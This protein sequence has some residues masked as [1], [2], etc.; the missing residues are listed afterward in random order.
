MKDSDI[1]EQDSGNELGNEAIEAAYRWVVMRDR[2][3]T[4]EEATRLV[5]WLEADPANRSAWEQAS[6]HWSKLD[7]VHGAE[8]PIEERPARWWRSRVFLGSAAAAAA[9]IAVL[10]ALWSFSPGPADL[11][12][13]VASDP[14]AANPRSMLLSDGTQVYLDMGSEVIER[15]TPSERR[16]LLVRGEARFDVQ[17]NDGWPFVVR[18]GAVEVRAVGTAFNVTIGSDEIEVRVT[19]GR[20]QVNSDGPQSRTDSNGVLEVPSLLDAGQRAIVGMVAD[21]IATYQIFNMTEDEMTWALALHEPRMRLG[22]STL[23]Q[24]AQDF[25]RRTGQRVV[26]ADP[27]LRDIQFGGTFRGDDP[28]GFVWLLE[29]SYGIESERLPDGTLVLRSKR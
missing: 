24:I 25:E 28:Q 29:D 6:D 22:G 20:V 23:A 27:K 15:F 18:A 26:I 17:K 12:R 14:A 5:H 9:V 13:P 4:P 1:S 8:L 21:R 10:G 3:L 2:G 16:V 19:E 11:Q 7:L